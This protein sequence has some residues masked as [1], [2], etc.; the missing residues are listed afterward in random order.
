MVSYAEEP[1]RLEDARTARQSFQVVVCGDL[2]IHLR[3]GRPPL[4][5]RG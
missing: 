2:R 1:F 5:G 3:I 4:A